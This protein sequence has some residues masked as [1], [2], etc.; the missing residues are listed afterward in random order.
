MRVFFVC[1]RINFVY[2]R[3]VDIPF[4]F[5]YMTSLFERII[6]YLV[7]ISFFV[8]LVISSQ[9]FIFPFIVPK[10]LLFR[11][12][13]LVMLFFYLLLVYKNPLRYRPKFSLMNSSIL[14]FLASFSISSFVGV[15]WYKSFWDNHERMLGL[16]TLCHYVLYYFILSSV[17]KEREDWKLFSRFFLYAG[18]LVMLVGLWQRLVNPNALL[19]SGAERV[20]STLGNSIYV[21]SYGLF[22]AAL[23][24]LV[25]F[26]EKRKNYKLGAIGFAVLGVL[27][28]FLGGSRGSLLG[29]FAFIFIFLLVIMVLTRERALR[30]RIFLTFAV[31]IACIGFIFAFRATPFIKGLPAIG[32]LVETSFSFNANVPRVM[33][34]G[35][36]FDAW[37]EYPVF[38]WGPNNFFYAFNKYY[39]PEFLEHGWGETW[40]DNAHNIVMNTLAVQGIVGILSYLSIFIIAFIVLWKAYKKEK[41]TMPVLAVLIAFLVAHFVN[42]LFVFE[43]P[44]SY[45]YFFFLLAYISS[46]GSFKEESVTKTNKSL[47]SVYVGVVGLI[48]LVVLFKTDVNAGKA[49]TSTLA[50]IRALHSPNGNSVQYIEKAIEH[51]SP[52]IDDIR[53]DFARASYPVMIDMYNKRK[54]AQAEEIYSFNV[55]ELRK[56]LVLH[57]LDIRTHLMLQEQLVVQAQIKQNPM[58]LLE[59]EKLLETALKES[60]KR[61]QYKFILAT[62][63][64]QSGKND[65]AIALIRDAIRDDEKIYISWYQLLLMYDSLGKKKEV[66]ALIIEAKAKGIEFSAETIKKIGVL[67]KK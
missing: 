33:A 55:A 54:I 24:C 66:E 21:S 64:V 42:N 23:G 9:V 2:N 30:K 25:F 43:N 20:A 11:S 58:L 63:K 52:H 14:F 19:N 44:T 27:G 40:F 3:A 4:L 22:L 1:K 67:Q 38:G 62:V 48:I 46:K 45:L 7:L 31:F 47:S 35:V 16:F 28:I 17:Y 39:R 13:V 59:A 8:P 26:E 60:P 57:P 36:A 49:N 37:K 65:E 61:Q 29:F 56:N 41:I 12:L 15:D 50:A 32:R 18:S 6:K 53:A 5:F 10:I 51:G 34:W